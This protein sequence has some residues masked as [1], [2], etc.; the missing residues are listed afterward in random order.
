[1]NS[2]EVRNSLMY[3]ADLSKLPQAQFLYFTQDGGKTWIPR[4]LPVKIGTVDFMDGQTGWLLGKNDPDPTTPTQLYQTT[5][6]GE[7]WTQICADCPLPIG[8]KLQFLD[9]QTG[10]AF[11]PLRD[12]GYYR[13]FDARLLEVVDNS[14][15]FY[16]KDGGHSWAKVEPKMAP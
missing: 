16:T 12:V 4:P 1:L 6:A 11:Y 3:G 2:E 9:G 13:Y 7:T 10:F 15:I 5:N 8:G 14:I